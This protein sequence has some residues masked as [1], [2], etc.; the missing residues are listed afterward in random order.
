MGKSGARKIFTARRRAGRERRILNVLDEQGEVN[1]R[2]IALVGG[3]AALVVALAA[4]AAG[5]FASPDSDAAPTAARQAPSTVPGTILPPHGAEPR[6]Y[7]GAG[8]RAQIDGRWR[9]K[10]DRRDLGIRRGYQRGRFAGALVRTPFVPRAT[11]ISGRGGS[12]N[13]KGGVA[14]YRTQLDVPTERLYAIRF[15]SI[16]HLAQIYL[17]GKRVGTHKGEYLPFEVRARLKPGVRHSLVVRADWRGPRAM[18]LDGWHRL[19]FNFGGVNRGVSIRPI[20]DSELLHPYMRTRLEGNAA[21]VSMRVHVRNNA[22]ERVIGVRGTLTRGSRSVPVNFVSEP[23][24]KTSPS[25]LKGV[26]RLENAELWSPER[27]NLWELKLEVPG[28]SSYRARV[29]LRDVRA[30]GDRL[31]LN[32]RSIRLRGAS[33]HEDAFGRGDALLPADQDKLVAQLK[34]IGANA[35][36]SQHPLDEGLLERLDAAGIMVWLGV[37]RTDAPGAWTARGAER[38]RV[39]KERV[40]TTVRQSALHPSIITWNLANE[41][42]NQGHPE[43]QVPY[44]DAMAGELQKTDPGRPVALDIWGA[45]PPKFNSLIFRNIDMIGWTNY[46]GWYESTNA[47]AG[48]LRGE[49]RR[50][51]ARLRRVFPSKVIAVT[52]FGAEANGRNATTSPGGYAFQSHLLDLHLSTYAQIP[53]LAGALIWNLRDFAVAPSFAG[54]SIKGKVPGIRI[55]KGVNQKGLFDLRSRAKPSVK[56]VLGRFKAQAAADGG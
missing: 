27:P 20:G 40:R 32:G 1:R 22:A 7:A 36:R 10:S 9:F 56:V 45:H 53:N 2:F 5:S 25:V 23:V 19:W 47:S 51:L 52:E 38:V 6:T 8:G 12:L 16:N 30:D 28:E 29:G 26:V 43:G 48:Q 54:G 35:T 13:F 24:S 41:V 44:I 55:V 50:R 42:A 4:I 14:W 39:A 49:I 18:K 17:D 34:A 15:E 21:V 33:I 3:L 37:G 11:Q 46:I 31:L